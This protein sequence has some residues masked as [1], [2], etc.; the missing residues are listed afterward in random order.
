MKRKLISVQ[1]LSYFL[2]VN[3]IN[4]FFFFSL[5]VQNKLFILYSLNLILFIDH[6]VKKT[7]FSQFYGKIESWR[8]TSSVKEHN[9]QLL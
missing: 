3:F 7:S 1:I 6:E 2:H 4:S 9:M 8:R 5:D